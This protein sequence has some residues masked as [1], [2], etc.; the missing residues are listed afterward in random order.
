VKRQISSGVEPAE[1]ASPLWGFRVAWR[2]ATRDPHEEERDANKPAPE[3]RFEAQLGAA[4][5][6][7]DVAESG[8]LLIAK[9]VNKTYIEA[10][11]LPAKL[12][13]RP[14]FGCSALDV[15]VGSGAVDVAKFLIEFLRAKPRRE[16]LKMALASGNIEL[17]RMC[18]GLLPD[19]QD[20]RLDLLEVAS[21]FH[22]VEVLA[23][24]FRDTD[25]FEKELF[26]GFAIRRHLAD[27]LL[28]VS[29]DRFKPWW[30][31]EAGAQWAPSHD[32]E[33]KS[34]PDGFWADGGWFKNSEGQM[35][36]VFVCCGRVGHAG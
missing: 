16:T 4:N 2:R 23:W 27:A 29:V 18:W 20:E 36:G 31:V 6:S 7:D 3:D 11:N 1:P 19:E 17:V 21:D 8:R 33:F 5:A 13:R 12:L 22:R 9:D 24:L 26:V 25:K 15:A 28:T 14:E 34:A 10:K 35:K 32:L 30:A